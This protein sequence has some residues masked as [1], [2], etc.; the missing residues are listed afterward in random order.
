MRAPLSLA[1]ELAGPNLAPTVAEMIDLSDLGCR[2]RLCINVAFGTFLTMNVEGF[3]AI[4][5]W[6]AWREKQEIGLEFAHP[7]PDDVTQYILK[8]G[9]K[10][11]AP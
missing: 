3:T 2:L 5:G 8:L 11:S 4:N 1:V 10:S 9:S 6:V 7:M